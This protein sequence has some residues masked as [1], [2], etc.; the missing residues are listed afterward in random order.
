MEEAR[1]KAFEMLTRETDS[2][3]ETITSLRSLKE[4]AYDSASSLDKNPVWGNAID[5]HRAS[6]PAEKREVFSATMIEAVPF[7]LSLMHGGTTRVSAESKGPAEVSNDYVDPIEFVPVEAREDVD[8]LRKHG[9]DGISAESALRI[10]AVG[11]DRFTVEI[12]D[13]AVA[14]HFW[15]VIREIQRGVVGPTH[16]ALLMRSILTMAVSAFE[17]LVTNLHRSFLTCSPG[18]AEGPDVKSF[19]LAD[20][21][22]FG[23]VQDAIAETIYRQADSFARKG[24]NHWSKWFSAKPLAIDLKELSYDWEG[25]HEVFE[26]R[27]V[28]V[29]NGSRVTR[30]YLRNVAPSLTQNV[31]EGAPIE[32]TPDYVEDALQGLLTLGTLLSYK[33]RCRLF[34]RDD[35]QDAA[36]WIKTEQF[37][38]LNASQFR[39]AYQIAVCVDDEVSLSQNDRMLLRVNGW[40]ARMRHSGLDS[41]VEEIRQWDT[42][43]LADP[44]QAARLILLREDERALASIQDLVE[45]GTWGLAELQDWPLFYWLRQDGKLRSLIEKCRDKTD[46]RTVEVRDDGELSIR[47]GRASASDYDE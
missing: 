41:C 5:R 33:V 45:R 43:A 42:S 6:I 28:V 44:F 1:A 26:R 23:S 12:E 13:P 35:P 27:N 31:T 11:D 46:Q 2:F 22:E 21:Y 16:A 20:L 8:G 30:Q 9:L 34:K 7:V 10:R 18:A 17:L 15:E 38:L 3:I 19:S 39:A 40:I 47:I 24:L 29:H 37:D 25:L 36:D 4:V 14:W 32:V